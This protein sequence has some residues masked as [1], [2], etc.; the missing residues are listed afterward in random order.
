M[1]CPH[2]ARV[3]AY[4]AEALPED[5]MESV[6]LHLAACDDCRRL[7]GAFARAESEPADRAAVE[8]LWR[9]LSPHVEATRPRK[10]RPRRLFLWAWAAVPAAAAVVIAIFLARPPQTHLLS[11]RPPSPPA[12]PA[13]DLTLLARLEPP[14]LELPLEDLLVTRSTGGAGLAPGLTAAF[15]AYQRGDHAGAAQQFDALERQGSARFEVFLYH[16]ISLLLTRRPAE[17][18]P[19]FRKAAGLADPQRR[20]EAQW[21]LA[22]A[23]LLQNE[24]TPARAQLQAVCASGHSRAPD[25]CG[26]LRQFATPAR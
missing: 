12:A 14:P 5:Q 4:T 18:A 26:L 23:L 17:A 25:A 8:A 16:G 21:F 7:A 20:P 6:R 2:A 24:V 1:T 22:V 11:L 10:A 3:Q 19:L 15:Q 9:R 13:L